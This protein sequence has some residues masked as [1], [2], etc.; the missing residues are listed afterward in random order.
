MVSSSTRARLPL[1]GH[2]YGQER[3]QDA[4][5]LI[6]EE[7]QREELRAEL[8]KEKTRAEERRRVFV[9]FFVFSPGGG[10]SN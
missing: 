5:A 6:E 1:K 10:N 4:E 3:D 2:T 8:A 9:L 7:R